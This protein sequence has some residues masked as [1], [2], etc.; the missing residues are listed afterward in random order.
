MVGK[1]IV[2]KGFGGCVRY[3]LNRDEAT[4]LAAEG[5]NTENAATI[6]R[7]FTIQQKMNPNLGKAVGHLVLS[8]SSEDKP[9]LTPEIMAERGREYLKLMKI[10]NTQYVIVQHTDKQHPHV[11]IVY[12]RVDNNGKTISDSNNYKAS[13]KACRIITEKYGYHMG[14]GKERVNRDSLKGREKIRYELYDSINKAI[15]TAKSWKDFEIALKVQEI[16]IQFKYKGKTK[17]VQGISFSKGEIKF[18]GSAIDSAFS[19]SKLNG[20]IK[21]NF[22]EQQ[23]LENKSLAQQIRE[24]VAAKVETPAQVRQATDGYFPPGWFDLV[25]DLGNVIAD[26]IDDEEYKRRKRHLSR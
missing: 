14:A 13:I 10:E 22:A 24:A 20:Q 12:N 3:L 2:G 17:E 9:L 1:Q 16:N 19:Y 7:D 6:I 11:H 8:W 25:Q 18:K 21:L 15:R 26:D 4:I 5:L 23:P